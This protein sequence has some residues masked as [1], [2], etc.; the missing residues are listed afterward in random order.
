MK[1]AKLVKVLVVA[2]D[3]D[4]AVLLLRHWQSNMNDIVLLQERTKHWWSIEDSQIPVEGIKQHLLFLHAW[5]G[6]D[7]TSYVYG[8]SKKSFV[9][10]L[11]K[12]DEIKTAAKVFSNPGSSQDEIDT[13]SED[14]FKIM[15]G[16]KIDQ[17]L[18]QIRLVMLFLYL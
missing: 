15:Y 17:P 13:H 5:S 6:S 12:C 4:V 1:H 11:K 14:I 8:K 16:G 7:T 18:T 2:D 3:T 9:K 10:L